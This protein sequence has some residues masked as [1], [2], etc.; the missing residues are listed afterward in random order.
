MHHICSGIACVGDGALSIGPQLSKD[1][2]WVDHALI[3]VSHAGLQEVQ[4]WM[5]KVAD[6]QHETVF[7]ACCAIHAF[8]KKILQ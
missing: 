3:C 4:C 6:M 7:C 5:P 1:Q 8:M 2:L